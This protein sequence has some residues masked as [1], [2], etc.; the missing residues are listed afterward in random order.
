MNEKI[1][2]RDFRMVV[3]AAVLACG[4]GQSSPLVPVTGS[5]TLDG[6]P[7][8]RAQVLFRPRNGRPSFAITDDNGKYALRY[9]A[10]SMG[11]LP[12]EHVVSVTTAANDDGDDNAAAKESLPARYNSKSTLSVTVDATHRT[13]DFDLQSK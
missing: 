9:T 10:E 4:C 2:R 8:P 1:L 7:L 5:V 6:E 11:A 13:H 12:G 3:L